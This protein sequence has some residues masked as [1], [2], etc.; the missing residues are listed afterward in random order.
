M[1]CTG[2]RVEAGDQCGGSHNYPIQEERQDGCQEAD[3]DVWT[4]LRDS[5]AAKLVG[6]VDSLD[7]DSEQEGDVKTDSS[8]F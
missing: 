4:V 5:Q 2:I 3:E 6:L 1:D 7:K 8:C